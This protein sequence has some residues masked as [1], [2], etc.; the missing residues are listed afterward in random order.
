[1]RLPYGEFSFRLLKSKFNHC[2]HGLQFTILFNQ[3]FTFLI[4]D[5][6]ENS[7][8]SLSKKQATH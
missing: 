5:S 4:N 8:N 1:M 3:L 2:F 7:N 6:G